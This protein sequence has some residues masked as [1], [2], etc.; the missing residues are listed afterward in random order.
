VSYVRWAGTN[1]ARD[2]FEFT[3]G[4]VST[5]VYTGDYGVIVGGLGRI[6]RTGPATWL[7]GYMFGFYEQVTE[8]PA[9]RDPQLVD[10]STFTA[11]VRY[12]ASPRVSVYLRG[13][14][15]PKPSA[16]QRWGF[17]R[18]GAD[19]RLSSRPPRPGVLR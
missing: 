12:P 11:M 16:G 14:V 6:A 2:A 13:D 18:F 19:V 9:G 3:P 4:R 1:R 8:T 10:A 5:A 17:V 15:S 7:L